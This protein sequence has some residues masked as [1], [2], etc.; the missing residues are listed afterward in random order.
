MWPTTGCIHGDHANY[1]STQLHFLSVWLRCPTNVN[2]SGY[3][4]APYFD[5]NKSN[6]IRYRLHT[7][8]LIYCQWFRTNC[9]R[10]HLLPKTWFICRRSWC[11]WQRNTRFRQFFCIGPIKCSPIIIYPCKMCFYP[12][13]LN[14]WEGCG[15]KTSLLWVFHKHYTTLFFFLVEKVTGIYFLDLG[16]ALWSRRRFGPLNGRKIVLPSCKSSLILK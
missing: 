9:D 14:F 5:L 10:P 12:I 11:S 15:Y 7:Q 13:Y 8:G 1:M 3:R 16:Q 4:I 2:C 6:S